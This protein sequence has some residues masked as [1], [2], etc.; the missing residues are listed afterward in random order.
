MEVRTETAEDE[1]GLLGDETPEDCLSINYK[2]NEVLLTY[3]RDGTTY[4][5]NFKWFLELTAFLSVTNEVRLAVIGMHG[6]ESTFPI[7]QSSAIPTN[8]GNLPSNSP[9]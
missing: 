9:A 4:Y 8:A 2:G 7:F 3:C 6:P 5:I 1:P